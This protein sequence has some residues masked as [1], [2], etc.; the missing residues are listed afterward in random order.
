MRTNHPICIHTEYRCIYC[1]HLYSKSIDFDV[2]IVCCLTFCI[3]ITIC[4]RCAQAVV[5]VVSVHM[6]IQNKI[7]HHTLIP[8]R[9]YK[10]YDTIY[11]LWYISQLCRRGVAAQTET[12]WRKIETINRLTNQNHEHY[13]AR[14]YM[15]ETGRQRDCH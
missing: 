2:H 11:Y 15:G 12:I 13:Y 10:F 9:V 8:N 4:V 7:A 3:F 14:V 5:A 6:K 1:T